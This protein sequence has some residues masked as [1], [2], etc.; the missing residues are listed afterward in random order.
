MFDVTSKKE[1]ETPITRSSS[2]CYEKIV[3]RRDTILVTEFRPQPYNQVKGRRVYSFDFKFKLID[4]NTNQ[5]VTSQS[6][7]CDGID[8]IDYNEFT[9]GRNLPNGTTVNFNAYNFFPY[10]PGITMPMNQYNP[11]S[12]RSGFNSRK[13]LKSFSELKKSANN[14]AVDVFYNTLTNYILR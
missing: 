9:R 13:E 5:L 6:Q 3:T 2:I 11:S 4:A 8:N 7:T 1:K 12:W 10:N 14:K